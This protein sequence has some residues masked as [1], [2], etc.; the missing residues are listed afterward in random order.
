MELVKGIGEDL[1]IKTTWPTALTV[2]LST[3]NM[4]SFTGY[5]VLDEW[6]IAFS[7]WGMQK[8]LNDYK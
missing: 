3:E 6:A 8:H 1:S 2:I 4:K 7:S 5:C